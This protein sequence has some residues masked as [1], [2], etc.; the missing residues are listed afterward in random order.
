MHTQF[1]IC[2]FAVQAV[3]LCLA[4]LKELLGHL[5]E[6]RVGK[7]VLLL[8]EIGCDLPSELLQLGLEQICRTAGGGLFVTNDLLDERGIDRNGG[9]AV[10]ASH[11]ALEFLGH[12]LVTLAH[13]DVE[14]RLCTNDLGGRRNKRRVSHVRTNSRNLLQHLGKLV[15]LPCYRLLQIMDCFRIYIDMPLQ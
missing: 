11:N 14:H 10:I 8:L 13:D 9:F 5:G 6:E 3:L 15:R 2:I 7:H 1:R 12:R 4:V